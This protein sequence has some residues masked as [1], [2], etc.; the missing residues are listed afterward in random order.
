MSKKIIYLLS[1]LMALSLVF[2]SCKKNNP[3]DPGNIG[4]GIENEDNIGETAGDDGL[5]DNFDDIPTIDKP[6]VTYKVFDLNGTETYRNSVVVPMGANGNYI[7]V[8][9]ENRYT[10]AKSVNDIALDGETITDIVYNLNTKSGKE[11]A[12][13]GRQV[14]GESAGTDPKKSRAAIL[15]YKV[16][17]THV[18]IVASQGAGISR[19]SA[20]YE[21]RKWGDN[22][23]LKSNLQ[24]IVGTLDENAGAINFSQ[25]TDIKIGGQALSDK[26]ESMM[27]KDAVNSDF[28]QFGTHSGR[29]FV[30]DSKIY[31]PI[32]LANQGNSST[33]KEFMGTIILTGT[34]SSTDV[35]DWTLDDKGVAFDQV[36]GKNLSKQKE[37][38]VYDVD[39]STVK[40]VTVPNGSAADEDKYLFV[41][42]A[43]E[44]PTKT[45]IQAGDGSVGILKLKWYGDQSY[46]ISNYPNDP[47]DKVIVMHVRTPERNLY[48]NLTDVNLSAIEKSVF[49]NEYGKSSSV[50]VL[51]DGTIIT[52]AEEGL[53]SG[54]AQERKYNVVF[55]RYSQRYLNS[56]MQ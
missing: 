17:P 33:V 4:G 46:T 3:N 11:E 42:N 28:A 29:G 52:L 6:L 5:Y 48:I 30:K 38:R 31:V 15:V 56:I 50:D 13:K 21:D 10:S 20:N 19:V 35:T 9:S 36:S 16:D 22:T 53:S 54:T 51:P 37:S 43:K 39:A 2:A 41:G 14:V 24:Y 7:A 44:K 40:Y 32:V 49:I 47:A 12:W 34:F 26:I 8:F 27:I 18:V 1:L 55:K 23:A 25:W 45:G